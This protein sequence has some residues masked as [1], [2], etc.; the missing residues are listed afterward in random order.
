MLAETPLRKCLNQFSQA[1]VF[2]IIFFVYIMTDYLTL[3]NPYSS[4]YLQIIQIFWVPLKITYIMVIWSFIRCIFSDPGKVPYNWQFQLGQ[5]FDYETA[6][7]CLFCHR[8][9]P[10]RCIHCPW[11]NRCVLNMHF[12]FH[13]IGNCVGYFNRKFFLLLLFY[14]NLTTLF[15]VILLNLKVYSI[16]KDIIEID[17]KLIF[18]YYIIIP[19]FCLQEIKEQQIY[20][21]NCIWCNSISLFN[22]SFNL[23][24]NWFQVMGNNPWLWAF[25]IFGVNG[26]PLGDGIRWE[27]NEN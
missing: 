3:K 25:P 11:C 27:R 17:W 14:I 5:Q 19:T 21:F 24:R 9:K 13:M 6:R 23:K 10:D 22:F 8:F 16:L 4:A 18:E 7:Y 1:I 20:M 2:Y 26:K 15:S 12:H